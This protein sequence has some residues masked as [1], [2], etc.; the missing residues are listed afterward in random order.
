MDPHEILDARLY[1][2]HQEELERQEVAERLRLAKEFEKGVL[3]GANSLSNT[4]KDFVRLQLIRRWLV[5]DE[6]LESYFEATAD[7]ELPVD[8][9][10]A[11]KDGGE[12]F[13]KRLEKHANARLGDGKRRRQEA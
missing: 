6:V 1:D 10:D 13:R 3:H 9:E 11:L 7:V 5:S 8:M 12:A 4:T 2:L